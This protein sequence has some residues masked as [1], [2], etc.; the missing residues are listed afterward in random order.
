MI[1]MANWSCPTCGNVHYEEHG[2][3]KGC[4]SCNWDK[5]N[6]WDGVRYDDAIS[7]P[8]LLGFGWE[9]PVCGNKN[10]GEYPEYDVCPLCGWED[11]HIQLDDP[12]Y[13]GGANELSL[14]EAK[15]E[16]ETKKAK[17]A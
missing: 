5:Y 17:S 10:V 11:D 12:N 4:V 14:N 3:D 9:C 16:W 6:R 13:D 7:S 8:E 2:A 15:A 1:K